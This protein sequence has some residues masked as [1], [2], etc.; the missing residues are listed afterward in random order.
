MVGGIGWWLNGHQIGVAYPA[1]DVVPPV[2]AAALL[3]VAVGLA[4]ALCSPP[5]HAV[6]GVARVA[7]A[8]AR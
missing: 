3:A 5:P 8:V 4:G 6:G 7:P 2:S 1:L